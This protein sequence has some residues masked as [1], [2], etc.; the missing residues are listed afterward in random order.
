MNYR[1]P[2]EVEVIRVGAGDAGGIE[3]GGIP[4]VGGD[5]RALDLSEEIDQSAEGAAL[6]LAVEEDDPSVHINDRKQKTR[7]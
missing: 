6:G 7:K 1:G 3:V 5:G 2:L 4:G